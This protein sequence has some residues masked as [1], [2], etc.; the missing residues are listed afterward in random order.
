MGGKKALGIYETIKRSNI[1]ITRVPAR[2]EK[3]LEEIMA[4]NSNLARNIN[5][6]IQ[7]PYRI[8]S[9]KTHHS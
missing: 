8:N 1:C 5:L 2:P 9:P 7:I 4:K 6:Q 3:I